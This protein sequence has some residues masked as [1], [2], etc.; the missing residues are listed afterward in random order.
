M[1]IAPGRSFRAGGIARMVM[2]RVV[3][4]ARICRKHSQIAVVIVVNP[5]YDFGL[6]RIEHGWP[7]CLP[8]KTCGRPDC[9]K[10]QQELLLR[11]GALR[12]S[13]THLPR[14]LLTPYSLLSMVL[15]R[16]PHGV[17]NT[18]F[19]RRSQKDPCASRTPPSAIHHATPNATIHIQRLSL[20]PFRFL[21]RPRPH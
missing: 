1:R 3:L 11:F 15:P 18:F 13:S 16:H 6:L 21:L 14:C 9:D 5:L 20:Q 19:A 10:L 7:I 17:A 4:A 8:R 2:E 12:F